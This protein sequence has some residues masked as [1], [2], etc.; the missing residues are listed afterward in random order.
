MIMVM[1]ESRVCVQKQQ[2]PSPRSGP[3]T[4]HLEAPTGGTLDHPNPPTPTQSDGAVGRSAIRDNHFGGQPSLAVQ[5]VEKAAYVIN[6]IEG[7]DND[8]EL[9]GAHSGSRAGGTVS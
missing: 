3:P 5:A 8:G 6:L 1:V 4:I 7:R 2:D 9:G